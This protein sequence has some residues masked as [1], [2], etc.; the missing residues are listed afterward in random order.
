MSQ[1]TVG[2]IAEKVTDAGVTIDSLN[3]KDGTL[4]LAKSLKGSTETATISTSKTLD[5]STYNNFV[6]TLGN[7]SNTL[8]NPSTDVT[9]TIGTTGVIIFIQP[10]SSTA[11]T[12]SLE[13]DYETVGGSGLTLSST[14]SAYDVVPYII[15]GANSILLG[16]PQLAFS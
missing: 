14:N 6:L 15:K 12:V 13:S 5:F 9:A 3:I 8:S 10:S 4:A 1:L 2:T 16:S 7:G 11:G